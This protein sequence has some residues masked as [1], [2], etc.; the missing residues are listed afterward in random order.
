ML[1]WMAPTH[2]YRTRLSRGFKMKEKDIKEGGRHVGDP[3][4]NR[5]EGLGV[6]IIKIHWMAGMAVPAF[7]ASTGVT[8]AG[9]S[10]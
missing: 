6:D 2:V 8:E 3:G 5:K 10:L 9:R 1:L 7:N 4:E